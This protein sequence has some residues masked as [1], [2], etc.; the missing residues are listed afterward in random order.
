MHDCEQEF[1]IQVECHFDEAI[2]LV[3]DE[4]RDSKIF[5]LDSHFPGVEMLEEGFWHLLGVSF[6]YIIKQR[7]YMR[8]N[9]SGFYIMGT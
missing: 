2:F 9:H 6:I 8:T 5:G 4:I 7:L 3:N 1:Y